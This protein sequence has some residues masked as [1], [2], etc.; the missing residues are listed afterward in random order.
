MRVPPR[1]ATVEKRR[2]EREMIPVIGLILARG[3][4]KVG[5]VG[6]MLI[7]MSA[8]ERDGEVAGPLPKKL[9]L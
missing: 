8:F 5:K 9:H 2:V 1:V 4:G 6:Y 7:D 3:V